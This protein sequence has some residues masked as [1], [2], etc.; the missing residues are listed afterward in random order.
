[1]SFSSCSEN[2]VVFFLIARR[3]DALSRLLSD[4]KYT[5]KELVLQTMCKFGIKHISAHKMTS[6]FHR[7]DFERAFRDLLNE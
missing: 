7:L 5:N 3:N 2:L 1:M 6:F 4:V